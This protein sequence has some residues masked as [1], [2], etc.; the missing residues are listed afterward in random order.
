MKKLGI[1]TDE[2]ADLPS[3]IIEKN[4]IGVVSLKANWPEVE[5]L[6]GENIFQKMREAEKRNIKTFAKT[7]QPSVKDFLDVFKEN[8]GKFEEIICL[9]I[10]SKHSGTFN[11]ALQAKRFLGEKD[12]KRVFVIDSLNATGGLGLLVLKAVGSI[13][14]GK[15][16]DDILK[17]LESLIPEIRLYALLEDPKW[18]EAS[19]RISHNLSNW[20][21]KFQKIGIRPLLG[22]KKGV[23]GAVGIKTG[24]KD[25][26]AAL[27]KE[28]ESKSKE[29]R[30]QGKKIQAVI[31]HGDNL[32]NAQKLK[33]II[34]G[35]L[36]N[37]EVLFVNLV[38]DIL[39]TILGA[40][41]LILA[42]MPVD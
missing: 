23:I 12:G 11:S 21:R 22:I 40:D 39:G 27:F 7:S 24:V 18:L 10:T 31:T 34:E 6:P 32:N 15:S 5:T 14:R 41:T 8:L 37:T 3:E 25:M 29:L 20:V 26:P 30:S 33:D 1:I 42:W 19:G 38:D 17:E 9:T 13:E 35:E 4:Q 2:G 16:R 28:L 36:K